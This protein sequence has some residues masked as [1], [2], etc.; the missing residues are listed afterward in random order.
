MQKISHEIG[1]VMYEASFEVFG[2]E[3]VVY[4][5]D[6]S[7]K[8]TTLRGM[9]PTLAAKPHLVSYAKSQQAKQSIDQE[10]Q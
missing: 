2:D 6:G 7:T 5:P 9:M 1:G 3:L 8:Q 10:K 4:L